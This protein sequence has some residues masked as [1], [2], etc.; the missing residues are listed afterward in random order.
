MSVAV[1]GFREDF[2][3]LQRLA[4]RL[5]IGVGV[6]DSH[7]FPDGEV[8]PTV[9]ADAPR[10]VILY[11][12]LH[13][14][15]ARLVELLLAADA[16][17]RAG[18]ARL[19]LVAPYLCYLRQDAV[20]R[21]GQALSRDVVGAWIGRAFDRVVTVQAHLHRT[22]SLSD[23]MGVPCDDFSIAGELAELSGVDSSCVV[24]GPD[25]EAA[26]W[27]RAAAARLGGKA[28]TFRKRRIDDRQVE[29]T[30]GP[31][32]NVGGRAVLLLDDICST[33]GTLERALLALRAAGA[34]SVDIAVAHALFGA[35]AAQRLVAAGARRIISSESVP[36]PTNTLE[37]DGVL[38]PALASE[39]RQ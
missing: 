1:F 25:E 7:R 4:G 29:L 21:P 16:C 19:V 31:E 38:A 8:L 35:D 28:A 34:R 39:V 3:P 18:V 20:F 32:A 33:G 26:P 12:S 27:V 36:H 17:R 6:I 23:V 15:N 24:I 2:G 5:G 22:T 11:R 14:P 9:P 10:V 30:L 37:L 13:H